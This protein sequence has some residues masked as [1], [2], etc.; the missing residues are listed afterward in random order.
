MWSVTR[1]TISQFPSIFVSTDGAVSVWI[2]GYRWSS[3]RLASHWLWKE[4]SSLTKTDTEICLHHR[5]F[6][7]SILHTNSC[8]LFKMTLSNHYMHKLHQHNNAFPFLKMSVSAPMS[9]AHGLRISRNGWITKEMTPAPV[10][11]SDHHHTH[12]LLLHL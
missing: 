3:F 8:P 4:G 9:A 6:H 11:C 1:I 2:S 12:S 7:F 10:F 5:K